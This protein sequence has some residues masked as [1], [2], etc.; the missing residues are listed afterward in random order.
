MDQL[1]MFITFLENMQKHKHTH[2]K[3]YL[4]IMYIFRFPTGI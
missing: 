3:I 2:I 4:N 1:G